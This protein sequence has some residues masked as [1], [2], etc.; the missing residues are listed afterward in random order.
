MSL[1]FWLRPPK[2]WLQENL[3]PSFSAH[4]VNLHNI[5]V[6]SSGFDD[7]S[8]FRLHGSV[9]PLICLL[10]SSPLRHFLLSVSSSP[11]SRSFCAVFKWIPLRKLVSER[12][13]AASTDLPRG[14]SSFFLFVALFY[15]SLS[16]FLFDLLCPLTQPWQKKHTHT[17]PIVAQP[18][19]WLAGNVKCSVTS[20]QQIQS[21][22]VQRQPESPKGRRGFLRNADNHT[23]LTALLF[24]SV[25]PSSITGNLYEP[26]ESQSDSVCVQTACCMYVCVC[27]GVYIVY[28]CVLDLLCLFDNAN[29]GWWTGRIKRHNNSITSWALIQWNHCMIN[30]FVSAV[31]RLY[32]RRLV[33]VITGA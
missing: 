32:N 17:K 8:H 18:S 15:F 14:F 24:P 16:L 27:M 19:K 5:L 33:P 30:D 1:A 31:L 20:S 23:K 10:L 4:P 26:A 2:T 9:S 22:E 13:S 6:R 3:K 12:S 25:P 29:Q 11:F 7:Y 21:L 28:V